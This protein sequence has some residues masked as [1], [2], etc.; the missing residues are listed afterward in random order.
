MWPIFSRPELVSVTFAG[1]VRL[2][3]SIERAWVIAMW[4]A[5]GGECAE[6]HLQQILRFGA[7]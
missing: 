1:A 2:K 7:A 3:L 5:Y 4:T 6:E